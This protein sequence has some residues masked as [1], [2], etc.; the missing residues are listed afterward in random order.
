[1]GYSSIFWLPV[2]AVLTALGLVLTYYFGR[3]RGTRAMMR[4][5][6]WSLI[7]IAAYLT[8]SIEMFWKIADAIGKFAS[9][10]VFSPVRWSGIAV[11]ALAAALFVGTRGRERRKAARLKAAARAEQKAEQ[12][13][14]AAATGGHPGLAPA[15]AITASAGSRG[16]DTDGDVTSAVPVARKPDTAKT[17]KAAKTSQITQATPAK[18]QG[19]STPSADDDMRDIEDILR[20]RGI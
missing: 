8:G 1:M 6:A 4:G 2:C 19:K 10:F 18:R 5:A 3:R 14:A 7:P 13:K 15:T 17:A 11:A 12:K 9:G 20:K 16:A